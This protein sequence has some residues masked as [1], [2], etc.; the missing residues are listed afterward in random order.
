MEGFEAAFLSGR[1][2]GG[3]LLCGEHVQRVV[4][5]RRLQ[6]R[7]APTPPT[8]EACFPSLA[9]LVAQALFADAWH[10]VRTLC[11]FKGVDVTDTL[12]EVA[13]VPPALHLGEL[14]LAL[15]LGELL[16]EGLYVLVKHLDEVVLALSNLAIL[17]VGLEV[18]RLQPLVSLFD[19]RSLV[20]HEGLHREGDLPALGC[21]LGSTQG[22]LELVL[23]ESVVARGDVV[24]TVLP[25][26]YYRMTTASLGAFQTLHLPRNL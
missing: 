2:A 23:G 16:L 19:T 8:F 15:G 18:L 21:Q 9:R 25:K 17:G 20:L 5:L 3:L 14:L 13:G 22:S 24:L 12:A 1:A 6:A 4:T 11:F 7:G 26:G 10:G